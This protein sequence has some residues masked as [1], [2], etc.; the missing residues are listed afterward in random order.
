MPPDV[1]DR[2]FEPFF[3]TKGESRGTGLG[4]AQV[5]GIVRK[6]DGYIN[7]ISEE[8][9]GT[10]FTVYLPA[11]AETAHMDRVAGSEISR[12]AGEKI[13]IVEDDPVVLEIVWCHGRSYWI[14]RPVGKGGRGGT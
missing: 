8:G 10:S 9:A 1:L 2:V 6:H 3:T 12:G 11:T 14:H 7:V 5:F 4:L 13:L